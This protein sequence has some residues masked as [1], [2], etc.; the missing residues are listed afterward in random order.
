MGTKSTKDKILV[1]DDQPDSVL[2]LCNSLKS[3][4]DVMCTKTG[5]ETLEIVFS[6]KCP[7]LI[8]LDIMMPD[9][10]GYQV[11]E[12]LRAE[13]STRE[14]PIIFLTGRT[15]D[16]EQVKGLESG[17]QDYI[18]KPFSIPVVVA[19]ITSVLNLRKEMKRRYMLKEQLET[20]NLQLDQR[21]CQISHELEEA[22]EA[23]RKHEEKWCT[24]FQ[25]TVEQKTPKSVLVV[26]DDPLNS[27]ILADSLQSQYELVCT[28]KGKEALEIAFSDDQPDII[29]LDIMMPEMDGYEVCS[30][31]KANAETRDIPVIFISALDQ[32]VDETKGLDLGAMDFVTKPFS[33]PVVNARIKAALRLREEMEQRIS[34]TRKLDR[35]NRD[36]EARVRMKTDELEQV[37]ED[38][39]SSERKYR[40]IYENAIE[41]IFQ[42]T[43]DGRILDASPSLATIL[44][45]ESTQELIE[46]VTDTAQQ[47]YLN[48]KDRDVLKHA[49]EK[50]GQIVGFETQLKKKNGEIIWVMISA[51]AIYDEDGNIEYIQ[52]FNIDITERK[53][54]EK[55][56]LESETRHRMVMEQS[57]D[58]MVVYDMKG[59]VLYINPAFTRVFG[60]T[61]VEVIGGKIDFIP[62][63]VLAETKEIIEKLKS[64]EHH[65]GVETQRY[66]KEKRII[67]V[68]M[69]YRVW[70]DQEGN[71]E[72]TVV[73]LR[74]I[75]KQKILKR[76][77]IQAQKMESI[78]TLA[79]GIAHDFNNILCIIT[80]C[81]ELAIRNLND[82]P[83]NI[84]Y[85]E[86][87]LQSGYRA[88][89]LVQQILN[90]SR[91]SE[92][93]LIPINI[94]PVLKEA[95]KLLRS[96]LPTTIQIYEY[97][98]AQNDRILG[99]STQI[100]QVL[101]NLCTNAAHAMRG[102][103][104]TLEVF[105]DDVDL[106]EQTTV[107]HVNL[108]P[109]AYLKLTVSDT[110]HGIPAEDVARIFDPYFTNKSKNEGTGLGLFIVHGI[111]RDHRGAIDVTSYLNK[112]TT[113]EIFLPVS[114]EKQI[115]K[116][117]NTN[118]SPMGKGNILFVDDE[119]NI[120]ESYG[121]LLTNF[122][123][124]VTG[125]TSSHN[126]LKI[127][128]EDPSRFD[129]V[130]TD[131]T[132]PK[133][134]GIQLAEKLLG[135]RPDLPV[136]LCS[137]YTEEISPAMVKTKGLIKIVHKPLIVNE[138]AETIHQCLSYRL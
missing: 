124:T 108:E 118:Q 30:R 112:G 75:S 35:L 127:F 49:L 57:P 17:A 110:G 89:D 25:K 96:T 104:G 64:D 121:E 82:D 78:G 47:L 68:S 77:L 18:V 119:I 85:I 34:L 45:Y 56:L 12:K 29:L 9:M 103:G 31:L 74:D 76:Q 130:L 72:G 22:R 3:K 23:L 122:G 123:Y 43:F 54:A 116:S 83:A 53:K 97:W 102:R 62:P 69:N 24:L 131:Y 91:T 125:V 32:E 46:T 99:N 73:T 8:L 10:D 20:L 55:A 39:K 93:G 36:L 120:V 86:K 87:V 80:G 50:E 84:R 115:I 94:L 33:I 105:L 117:E 15:T 95:L 109:G 126:A 61:P 66:D 52:G 1:V 88:R 133:M 100:H 40:S 132:M 26:D 37:H 51:K 114:T 92:E 106:L 42:V 58:P 6:E 129:L 19:R 138:I 65:I 107:G 136:I 81:A 101:M 113:F 21:I 4:F 128:S 70:N 7:D 134:T 16:L 14:I 27:L 63:A 2:P 59:N 90:F 71:P 5:R 60:W 48:A 13:E 44:G 98:N 41:G 38:L 79:S 28:T 135:I 111:V 67:D 137:G 11:L